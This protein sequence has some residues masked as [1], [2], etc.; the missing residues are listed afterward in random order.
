MDFLPLA[1]LFLGTGL[2]ALVYNRLVPPTG[3]L[4]ERLKNR[5]GLDGVFLFLVI[6][7]VS[8]GIVTI[9]PGWIALKILAYVFS[10]LVF[11]TILLAAFR[12]TKSNVFAVVVSLTGSGFV[13]FGI[14][15]FP[16]FLLLNSVL[17]VATLGAT[18]LLIRLGYLR[19]RFLF[20]VA[21]LWTIYDVLSVV[22]LYPKVYAPAAEPIPSILFPAVTVG[23]LTLGSGDFMFL[24]IFTLIVLRDFGAIASL[25]LA[26]TETIGLLVTGFFLPERDFA[27]PFLVVMTPLFVLVYLFS[28]VASRR[29]SQNRL[30]LKT[31]DPPKEADRSIN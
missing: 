29:A 8:Y 2:L 26:A 10:L 5:P 15:Q 27:F 20:L 7:A 28:H 25:L 9:V 24:T 6:A 22:L 16:S 31:N 18:T 12:W 13:F 19:T 1:G 23:Q 14:I 17:I 4:R 3:Q 30:R 21:G 11:E